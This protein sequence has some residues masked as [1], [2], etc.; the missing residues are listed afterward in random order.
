MTEYY[1]LFGDED[2]QTSATTSPIVLHATREVRLNAGDSI[3]VKTILDQDTPS[4]FRILGI[5]SYASTYFTIEKIAAY[6]ELVVTNRANTFT[7]DAVIYQPTYYDVALEDSPIAYYKMDEA[8]GDLVDA[9]SGVNLTGGTAFSEYQVAGATTGSPSYGIGNSSR[10]GRKDRVIG[11]IPIGST[12]RTFE[13]WWNEPDIG[14]SGATKQT[15]FS[16]GAQST[17]QA[18]GVAMY[19]GNP[20]GTAGR[21]EIWTWASDPLTANIAGLRDGNWHHIAITYAAGASQ[22][23]LYVDGAFNQ[24]MGVSGVLNTSS[25]NGFRLSGDIVSGSFNLEGKLDELAIYATELS[26]ARILAHYN[27]R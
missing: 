14:G 16:Y 19:R 7:A 1:T 17:R 5:P 24:N 2:R 11:A 21:V 10:A 3:G 18:I 27:A 25:A 6:T 4:T 13:F 9:I 26:A 8:S 22:F 23:K 20:S 12:A 15:L